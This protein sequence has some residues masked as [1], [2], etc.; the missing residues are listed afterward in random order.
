MSSEVIDAMA[1]AHFPKGSR[2]PTRA[3]TNEIGIPLKYFL[4]PAGLSQAIRKIFA[5]KLWLCCSAI[6]AQDQTQR[7]ALVRYCPK[8][9][10]LLQ[11]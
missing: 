5:K 1:G 2:L 3:P 6:V 10:N 4:V 7:Q 8:A 9:T 11:H